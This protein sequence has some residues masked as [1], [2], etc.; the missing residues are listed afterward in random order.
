M[1]FYNLHVNNIVLVLNPEP[2]NLHFLSL[3]KNE[4]FHPLLTGS[5]YQEFLYKDFLIVVVVDSCTIYESFTFKSS[6]T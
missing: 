3:G 4:L 2:K 1:S 5:G 6:M